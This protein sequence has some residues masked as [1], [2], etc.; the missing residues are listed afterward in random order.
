MHKNIFPFNIPLPF[1]SMTSEIIL[2]KQA[3]GELLLMIGVSAGWNVFYER[4]PY[5]TY[6]D[7]NASLSGIQYRYT[8]SLPLHITGQYLFKDLGKFSPFVGF[9]IGTIY[10]K[11]D[12]DM[13]LY[14]WEEEAWSF[15]IRPEVGV[16][17]PLKKNKIAK[18]AIRYNE[19]FRTS[20]LKDQSF[21]SL[22]IGL[23]FGK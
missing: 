9:G 23:V 16:T 21:L 20:S 8:N 11:R 2:V 4:K 18:L 10:T 1:P 6:N 12:T 19:A 3:S 7:G 13:G 5:S 22:G 14:R 17:F 15:S